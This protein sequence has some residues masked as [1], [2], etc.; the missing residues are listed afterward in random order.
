M[1]EALPARCS[2]V[3][4][5]ERWADRLHTLSE[6]NKSVKRRRVCGVTEQAS[7]SIQCPVEGFAH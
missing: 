3:R 2:E 7:C 1:A 6:D 4:R 5:G